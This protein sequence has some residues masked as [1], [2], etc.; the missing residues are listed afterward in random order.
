[1][2][3]KSLLAVTLL[4]GVTSVSAEVPAYTSDPVAGAVEKLS[5]I[6]VTFTDAETVALGALGYGNAPRVVKDG[7]DPTTSSNCVFSFKPSVAG[8]TLTCPLNKEITEEG[9]FNFYLPK[10]L[11]VINGTTL[12]EEIKITYNVGQTPEP[13][14]PTASWTSNP[15]AGEVSVLSEITVTFNDATTVELGTLGYSTAPKLVKEG[16]DPTNSANCN[17]CFK[18]SVDGKSI[19][20]PLSKTQE[21][22][23]TYIF[24]INKSLVLLDGEAMEDDIQIKYVIPVAEYSLTSE[25]ESELEEISTLTFAIDTDATVTIVDENSKLTLTNTFSGKTIEGVASVADNKIVVTFEPAVTES[26]PYSITFPE[27]FFAVDGVASN[28]EWTFEYRIKGT[29]DYTVTIEPEEGT[30]VELSKFV[31]TFEGSPLQLG[32][33]D[34]AYNPILL[35]ENNSPVSVQFTESFEGQSIILTLQNEIS[36]KGKYTLLIPRGLIKLNGENPANDL[37]FVYTVDP[38]FSGVSTIAP[39]AATAEYFDL[40]GIRVVSPTTGIYIKKSNN[41]VEKII[42]K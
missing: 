6:S 20:F 31:I 8:K 9:T 38:T 26:A 10:G 15:E 3:I 29:G 4:L 19:K 28:R 33:I 23:G 16:L 14:Q 40:N 12:D 25:N 32:S 35:N 36:K 7:L 34:S 37:R 30:V 13:E 27:G 42:I 24:Y 18:P 39:D 5:T 2:K 22:P 17:F 41:K 11:M 21:A 1:M